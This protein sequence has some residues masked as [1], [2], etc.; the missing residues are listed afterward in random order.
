MCHFPAFQLSNLMTSC[1]ILMF[2][3]TE[4][5]SKTIVL[6]VTMFTYEAELLNIKKIHFKRV[7]G[8]VYMY[9]MCNVMVCVRIHTS[10][11]T[12][13]KSVNDPDE[14]LYLAY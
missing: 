12:T 5:P 7:S 14:S 3:F 8:R 11:E 4:M 2:L 6:L 9:S 10:T 13:Y 1:V